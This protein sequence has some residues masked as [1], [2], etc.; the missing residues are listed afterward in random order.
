[1]FRDLIDMEDR[2]TFLTAADK[3]YLAL[4]QW[5]EQLPSKQSIQVRF[6]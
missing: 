4:V 5:I 1:M 3:Q 2:S 6:L